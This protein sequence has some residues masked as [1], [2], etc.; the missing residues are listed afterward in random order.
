MVTKEKQKGRKQ[1]SFDYEDNLT[2]PS[3]ERNLDLEQGL[4]VKKIVG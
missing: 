2:V 1:S 4:L 3:L